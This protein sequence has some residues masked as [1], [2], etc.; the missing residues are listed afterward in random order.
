MKIFVVHSNKCFHLD[1]G[2]GLTIGELKV[3]IK[4]A[5]NIKFPIEHFYLKYNYKILSDDS[6]TINEYNIRNNSSLQFINGFDEA[7]IKLKFK[8]E[9]IEMNNFPCFCCYSILDY[10]KKINEKRGYPIECQFFYSDEKAS[11]PLNDNDYV[12]TPILLKID[13]KYLKKGY[14]VVYDD[15]AE[16]YNIV[17]GHELENIKSIKQE[18]E[19]KYKL[20]RGSFEL[21]FDGN[22]LNDNKK[23]SDY[24]IYFQSTIYI[25]IEQKYERLLLIRLFDQSYLC[26]CYK[27]EVYTAGLS[28]LTILGIKKYCSET[29]LKDIKID[30]M[31]IIFRGKILDNNLDIEKEGLSG[32]KLELVISD[33]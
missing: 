2:L 21:L 1:I 32:R 7:S 14:K 16:T 28:D 12:L 30:K 33:N 5:I 24:N 18:I 3:L 6:K 27:G 20:P 31:K 19:A 4:D 11:T 23:L 26:I 22:V 10:K 13:D 15:G 29:I 9:V 8:D 25:V 17:E